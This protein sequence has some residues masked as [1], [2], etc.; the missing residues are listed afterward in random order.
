MFR[1]I[2]N[3]QILCEKKVLED[4]NSVILIQ[5]PFNHRPF[6]IEELGPSTVK[7]VETRQGGTA[8]SGV[9]LPQLNSGPVGRFSKSLPHVSLIANLASS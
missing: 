1:L 5:F 3:F 6:Y 8:L 4:R 9:S 7:L 2:L